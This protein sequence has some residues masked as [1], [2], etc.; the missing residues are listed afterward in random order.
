M[1]QQTAPADGVRI[2]PSGGLIVKRLRQPQPET[3]H[4]QIGA[5]CGHQA[6]ILERDRTATGE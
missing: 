5:V 1:E 4:H 2:I 6:K 3:V